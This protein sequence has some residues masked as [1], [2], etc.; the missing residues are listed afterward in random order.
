MID[1]DRRIA[2][3]FDAARGVDITDEEVVEFVQS[4]LAE[5]AFLI[6]QT[7]A[8]KREVLDKHFE[9]LEGLLSHRCPQRRQLS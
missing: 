4:M 8:G 7:P 9:A 1:A 6:C 5:L 3:R 2:A